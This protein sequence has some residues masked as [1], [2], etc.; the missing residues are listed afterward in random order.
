MQPKLIA[1]T[2]VL[3]AAGCSITE[4]TVGGSSTPPPDPDGVA[5]Q[6]SA[7]ATDVYIDV[8]YRG[9]VVSTPDPVCTVDPGTEITWR[10]PA[11]SSV[12][13]QLQFTDASPSARGMPL[14][15]DSSEQDGRQK[16]MITANNASDTYEY[17]IQTLHGG[18][19]PAII[20]R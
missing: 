18:V 8:E 13:F 12:A 7:G 15:V 4:P 3:V 14:S 20:I 19:D 5:C 10:A 9:N 17:E 6:D 2:I 11:G 16:V 1:I